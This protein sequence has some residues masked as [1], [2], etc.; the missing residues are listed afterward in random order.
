M[1]T[2]L[3]VKN[4]GFKLG[5]RMLSSLPPV[6]KLTKLSEGTPEDYK[7]A[8]V[9]FALHANPKATA[10][11]LLGMVEGLKGINIGYQVDLYEHSVQTATRALKDGADD[12]TIVC[13]LLH[14]IG[15]ILV[16]I[17]HGEVAG[18]LLR[19]YISPKNYWILT[20]HEIFQA[21]YYGDAIGIDKNV[22][23]R[24][25]DHE[26]YGACEEFCGRW[27]EV[28]FDPNYE[29]LPLSEFEPLLVRVLER[30]P[31]TQKGAL[32]AEMNSIKAQLNCYDF[33]QWQKAQKQ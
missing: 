1:A 21:F 12:E 32:D 23:D 2:A 27:D 30:T 13:G 29:S 10:K 19:P 8:Q 22:R 14:D 16:P 31:Y 33:D 6:A 3:V 20:N 28:A 7:N 25:K 18:S 15:E 9:H 11:R 5:S 24:L 17:C 26:F 4:H